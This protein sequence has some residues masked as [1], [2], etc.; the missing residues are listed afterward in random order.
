MTEE[1]DAR[2]AAA[3]LPRRGG[4]RWDDAEEQAELRELVAEYR[5]TGPDDW[6]QIAELLG[7]GRS[8]RS[9]SDYWS[10]ISWAEEASFLP[11]RSFAAMNRAQPPPLMTSSHVGVSYRPGKQKPWRAQVRKTGKKDWSMDF[12][13]E[14]SAARAY[15]AARV[16]NGDPPVN[17][18]DG[19]HSVVR[20]R[21][22]EHSARTLELA[23]P[24]CESP[25]GMAR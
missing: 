1:V 2:A 11:R 13:D 20:K 23:S 5:P 18:R 16:R 9:V 6:R 7:T 3:A 21:G 24:D 14:E 12:D 25:S 4:R 15:D 17:F 8:A 22:P 10:D 19:P